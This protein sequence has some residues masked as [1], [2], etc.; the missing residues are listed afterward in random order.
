MSF[1]YINHHSPPRTLSKAMVPSLLSILHCMTIRTSQWPAN[2][3]P[4]RHG[5]SREGDKGEPR[6]LRAAVCLDVSA[7][8]GYIAHT[9]PGSKASSPAE[10][11]RSQID[12][13]FL[14]FSH[15]SDA[16]DSRARRAVRSHVTKQQ[17]Q[18]EHALQ[19]ARANQSV[20]TAGPATLRS[21]PMATMSPAGSPDSAS[22]S[23]SPTASP[24][25]APERRLDFTEL[26][27]EAWHPYIPPIMVSDSKS[28]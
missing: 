26:Y 10:T 1:T 2:V 22:Q 12:F 27:P 25:Y 15:P 3:P 7:T 8:S 19:A 17:H 24:T 16:K 14:N 11:P 5:M 13:Q 4:T 20:T 9:S 18:R 21:G 23:P 28:I 6:R